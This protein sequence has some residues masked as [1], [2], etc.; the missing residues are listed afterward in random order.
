MQ[1]LYKTNSQQKGTLTDL[2]YLFECQ[3]VVA[4]DFS[5]RAWEEAEVGGS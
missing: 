1:N 4:H 3:E 2:R 5:P